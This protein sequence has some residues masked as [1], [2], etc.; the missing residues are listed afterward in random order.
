MPPPSPSERG[1]REG[2]VAF[3]FLGETLL[4]PHLYPIVEALATLRPTMRIDLWTGSSTTEAMLRARL[5]SCTGTTVRVRRAPGFRDG[6]DRRRG[7]PLAK[8]A[9]L[10]RLVPHLARVPV[11]IC[12]EQTSLWVPALL[13][14]RTRFIKT[15]H[16]AGSMS[17]RDDP[18]RRTAWRMLVPSERER[19]TYLNRGF[20][21]EQVVATGYVKASFARAIAE[22]Q[23]LF[24]D[25][26]PVILY[27]PHWQRHR[28]SWWDWGREIVAVLAGQ[29]RFNVILAPHQR[30]A[31]CEPSVRD[32]L[33]GVAGLSHVHVDLDSFALVDGSYT[34]AADIY[35]GDTSSQVVEF[36][37]AP[38]PCVFL[39]N[40]AIDWR[41][42]DD[43]GFWECGDV[44]DDL[45][46]L[47][48]AIEH[49]AERH[50]HYLA[51]QQ[52]FAASSLGDTS[53]EA[54]VRAAREILAALER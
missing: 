19:W 29:D 36:L 27:T 10:A 14:V 44:V 31:E 25:D 16:G 52:A 17:A 40:R 45:G 1:R 4:V 35:L 43:H 8:P 38:R 41:A 32:I 22:P 3:L 33:A 30:L 49:A 2:P 11:A 15:S 53:A 24:A 48:A 12:A 23:R 42:T 47:Q 7:G 37:A 18:R 46:Q 51:A 5:P 34:A 28:S 21:P 54:P 20:H 26:R 9:M 13:P 39:N 6:G 50:A